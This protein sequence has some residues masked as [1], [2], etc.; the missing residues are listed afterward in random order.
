MA[1][2]ALI[3]FAIG[4]IVCG[5]A[6]NIAALLA[7]RTIQGIGGGGLLSVTYVVLADLLSPRERPKGIL[8]IGI[9]WLVGTSCGPVM[10]GGFTYHATWRW[11]FWICLPFVAI[12]LFLLAFLRT[13]HQRPHLSEALK[14]VDWAGICL[15][16]V[17]LTIFLMAISWVS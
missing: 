1:I 13:P 17:S 8:L 6:P 16:V 10:G 14:M 12:S 2:A 3:I 5:A 7:G 15:F 9:V 4:T 11:I